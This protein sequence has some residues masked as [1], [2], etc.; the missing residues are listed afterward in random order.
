M[1]R[2][3]MPILAAA[4]AAMLPFEVQAS[5]RGGYRSPQDL[6]ISIHHVFAGLRSARCGDMLSPDDRSSLGDN[7]LQTGEPIVDLPGTPLIRWI[8]NCVAAMM[9]EL[10][11]PP[12]QQSSRENAAIIERDFVPHLFAPALSRMSALRAEQSSWAEVLTRRTF[13]ELTAGDRDQVVAHWIELT[14]GTPDEIEAFGRMRDPAKFHRDLTDYL[15]R[16]GASPFNE[17]MKRAFSILLKRDE[18]LLY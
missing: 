7:N 18:F 17:I 14:L 12:E 9:T 4:A 3:L 15:S 5:F 10:A 8:D 11:T 13:S 6:V 2:L 16:A 1:K